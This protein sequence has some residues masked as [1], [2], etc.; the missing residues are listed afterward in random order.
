MCIIIIIYVK[1]KC[2]RIT[3]YNHAQRSARTK[4]K[5][6]KEWS[7]T[8]ISLAPPGTHWS[9]GNAVVAAAPVARGLGIASHIPAL[10][11][12]RRVLTGRSCVVVVREF[13]YSCGTHERSIIF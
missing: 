4:K 12:R 9:G 6:K 10:A 2:V 8:I 13:I 3:K 11:H 7:Y 5:K 1:Y